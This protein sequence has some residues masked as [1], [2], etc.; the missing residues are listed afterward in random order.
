[1]EWEGDRIIY[2]Y[3]HLYIKL[4]EKLRQKKFKDCT[5]TLMFIITEQIFAMAMSSTFH[6]CLCSC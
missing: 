6:E 5:V 3:I 4:N 2:I 1:M